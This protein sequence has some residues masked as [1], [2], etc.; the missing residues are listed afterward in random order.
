MGQAHIYKK[1]RR[2][3]LQGELN[4][5]ALSDET[6]IEYQRELATLEEEISKSIFEEMM[7]T[8]IQSD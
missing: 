6:R 3:A 5:S 1:V 7:L 4:H 8:I 2:D